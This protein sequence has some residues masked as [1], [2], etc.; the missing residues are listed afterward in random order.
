[1]AEVDFGGGGGKVEANPIL[2]GSVSARDQLPDIEIAPKFLMFHHPLQWCVTLGEDGPILLPMVQH[3]SI[4]GGVNNVDEFGD[5]GVLITN[6]RKAGWILIDEALATTEDTPDGKSGY[7]RAIKARKG[8]TH[9]SAWQTVK[10]VAGMASKTH[11]KNS[12]QKWLLKLVDNEKIPAPDPA[13]VE[14]LL[15]QARNREQRA[16]SRDS[17]NAVARRLM[18]QASQQREALEEIQRSGMTAQEDIRLKRLEDEIARLK[19][20]K[21]RRDG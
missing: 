11:H 8:M 5:P 19:E 14:R 16:G 4:E 3:V 20:R 1:M 10:I 2:V 7:V 12:Y 17:D 21:E 13:I 18:S 15:E 9:T 6:K